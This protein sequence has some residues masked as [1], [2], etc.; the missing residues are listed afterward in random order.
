MAERFLHLAKPGGQTLI[1]ITDEDVHI[2][3]GLSASDYHILAETLG[4]QI[5]GFHRATKD[6]PSG[7]A[8]QIKALE[9]R[10]RELEGQRV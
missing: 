6:G 9:A 8:V 3:S 1:E 5:R 7:M 2:P 10:V 4:Q